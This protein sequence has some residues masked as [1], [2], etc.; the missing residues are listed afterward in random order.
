MITVPPA[1]RQPSTVVATSS[2]HSVAYRMPATSQKL[3]VGGGGGGRV[4]RDHHLEHAGAARQAPHRG[5]R[6]L[7]CLELLEPERRLV[8]VDERAG[9]AHDPDVEGLHGHGHVLH[10]GHGLVSLARP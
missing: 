7:A 6:E 10:D 1:A 3:A 9:G 8:E 5:H 4:G 2:T